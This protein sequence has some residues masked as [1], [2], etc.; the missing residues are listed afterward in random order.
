VAEVVAVVAQRINRLLQRPSLAATSEESGTADTWAGEAPVL[1][2][3]AAAS[4]Q[5]LVALGPRAGGPLWQ[6]DGFAICCFPPNLIKLIV[7]GALPSAA[8]REGACVKY[9]MSLL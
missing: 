6:T 2:G 7:A 9:S 3:L 4:V 5:G 1:A 8:A